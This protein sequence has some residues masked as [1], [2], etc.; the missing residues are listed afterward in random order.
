ML[1]YFLIFILWTVSAVLWPLYQTLHALK[2]KDQAE[3]QV[4][5]FYWICFVMASWFM[6]FFG[7]VI[8]IPF[9]VLAFYVDF[10]YEAQ[11]LFII[12]LVWPSSMGIETLYQFYERQAEPFRKMAVEKIRDARREFKE[13]AV[14]MRKSINFD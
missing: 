10:Y 6:H 12:Y 13:Q 3:V 2:V 9:Y 11:L 5:W 14:R 7:W 1:P 8:L 4:W